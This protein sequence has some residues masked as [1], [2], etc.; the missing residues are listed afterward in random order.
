M[1]AQMDRENGNKGYLFNLIFYS[2]EP[3][4]SEYFQ[5][6]V[7]TFIEKYPSRVIYIQSFSDQERDQLEVK[8][9]QGKK[10]NINYDQILITVSK[11]QLHEVPFVILPKLVPDLP[12]YLVWGQNPTSDNEILHQLE[13]LATR[14]VFDSECANDLQDFSAKMLGK[15]AGLKIDFMDVSWANISGWRDVIAQ[16]FNSSEKLEYLNQCSRLLIKY[17]RLE[18]KFIH[19]PS[20]QAIFLQGWL[21]AQLGWEY[22][23]IEYKNE[24]IINYALQKSNLEVVLKPQ[25]RTTLAPGRVFEV[26]FHGPN[27]LTT[28]LTLAEKQSKVMIYISTLE[29]CELPFSFPIPD[30]SKGLT[31]MKEVFYYRASAHYRNMLGV[32]KKIPWNEF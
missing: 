11:S 32:I 29:K 16:T 9:Q 19:H 8:T 14:F 23:T 22:K 3:K 6:V 27:D 31:A 21:A 10:D 24:I 17:N 2:H 15:I 13:K 12:I 25:E 1:E 20:I 5:K 18:S 28:T 30:M 26:E 7:Q 4:R